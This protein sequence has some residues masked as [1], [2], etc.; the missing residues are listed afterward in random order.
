M[1]ELKPCPFC[2]GEAEIE[3]MGSSRQS[4]IVCCS[5][6]GAKVE[7]GSTVVEQANWNTRTEHTE[8][9]IPQIKRKAIEHPVKDMQYESRFQP[10]PQHLAD[11]AEQCANLLLEIE[12][13]K[14]E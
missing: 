6:C 4:M 13:S 5:M 10:T 1:S 7:C 8:Q 3:R 9:S 12:K 2:G 11:I 14:G